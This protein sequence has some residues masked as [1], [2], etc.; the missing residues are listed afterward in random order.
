MFTFVF[1]WFV[2]K[3]QPKSPAHHITRDLLSTPNGNKLFQVRHHFVI[4]KHKHAATNPLNISST[5]VDSVPFMWFLLLSHRQTFLWWAAASLGPKNVKFVL[6]AEG[7]R[8][9]IV[10]CATAPLLDSSTLLMHVTR[11]GQLP[12]LCVCVI[13]QVSLSVT[14]RLWP[15]VRSVHTG[16]RRV[17]FPFLLTSRYMSFCWTYITCCFTVTT[18]RSN[19]FSSSFQCWLS[20]AKAFMR[21]GC[22]CMQSA[23]DTRPELEKINKA[24]KAFNIGR[25]PLCLAA[26]LAGFCLSLV[27]I[28]KQETRRSPLNEGL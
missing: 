26:H 1:S 3:V 5:S 4:Y 12:V 10:A 22:L 20:A 28:A 14:P 2:S 24:F 16:R 23:P 15:P 27:C 25:I 7:R 21:N 13:I 19:F 8:E 9:E 18:M 11:A 6:R 17:F